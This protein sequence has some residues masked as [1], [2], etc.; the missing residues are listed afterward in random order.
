MTALEISARPNSVEERVT[1][2][3]QHFHQALY[4]DR[5]AATRS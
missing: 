4:P 2:L 1:S 3:R 5:K